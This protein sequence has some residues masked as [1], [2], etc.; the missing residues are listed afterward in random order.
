MFSKNTDFGQVVH[1][2]MG[3][4]IHQRLAYAGA[5]ERMLEAREYLANGKPDAV[6][7]TIEVA[8][9]EVEDSGRAELQ[10]IDNLAALPPVWALDAALSAQRTPFLEKH[11][12]ANGCRFGWVR[13]DF[14]ASD[15]SGFALH[16]YGS[17]AWRCT[18]GMPDMLMCGV[19][20]TTL[21]AHLRGETIDQTVAALAPWFAKLK[22]NVAG[23][24]RDE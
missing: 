24:G 10:I 21:H 8:I 3:R 12:A 17:D 2:S 20:L 13:G 4:Q 16:V 18:S 6:A 22:G 9:D 7:R 14:I 23:G 11:A 5:R 15:D 19:G 1:V